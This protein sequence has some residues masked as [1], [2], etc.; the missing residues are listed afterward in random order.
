M[1]TLILNKAGSIKKTYTSGIVIGTGIVYCAK[2]V[3]DGGS[4]VAK[5]Y[6][7]LFAGGG[8]LPRGRV[9]VADIGGENRRNNSSVRLDHLLT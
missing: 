3:V 6:L 2:Q 1:I 9:S 8:L 4:G 7:V 5:R